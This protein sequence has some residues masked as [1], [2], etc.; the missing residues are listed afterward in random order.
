MNFVYATI[1]VLTVAIAY[2]A[3]DIWLRPHVQGAKGGATISKAYHQRLVNNEAYGIDDDDDD[4]D[5][6]E[7]ARANVGA[8]NVFS[9]GS[10]SSSADGGYLEVQAGGMR[11]STNNGQHYHHHDMDGA[12]GTGIVAAPT[13]AIRG[14]SPR[15]MPKWSTA[16]GSSQSSEGSFSL[17]SLESD[18][19]DEGDGSGD[20]GKREEEEDFVFQRP[21][22]AEPDALGVGRGFGDG[23][24]SAVLLD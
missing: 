18:L 14:K 10:S 9:G 6:D 11:S 5:E 2:K 20:N 19:E 7:D 12:L 3:Y 23:D 17:L 4:Y 13:G 16:G 15:S 21:D 22:F 1:V 8:A 24:F